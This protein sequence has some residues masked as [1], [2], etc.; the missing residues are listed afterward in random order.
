MR[1]KHIRINKDAS[2]IIFTN[3]SKR[4]YPLILRVQPFPKWLF[5]DKEVLVYPTSYGPTFGSGSILYYYYQDEFGKPLNDDDS[6]QLNNWCL[7]YSLRGGENITE[8]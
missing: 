6:Q 7:A 5:D 4:L 2:P 3:S 8:L 1:I